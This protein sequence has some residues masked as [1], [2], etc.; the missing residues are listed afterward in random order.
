MNLARRFSAG[1]EGMYEWS[2]VG[3][4]E[5]VPKHIFLHIQRENGC[6]QSVV[7]TGLICS[8]SLAPGTEVPG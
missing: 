6:L 4:I 5:C 7:P 2:P 8:F 1:I 3:T